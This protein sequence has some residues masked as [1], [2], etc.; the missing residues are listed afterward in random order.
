MSG[1]GKK[2]EYEVGKCADCGRSMKISPRAKK[3][4]KYCAVCRL[5]RGAAWCDGRTTTCSC[6]REYVA[7]NGAKSMQS[8]GFCF[9]EHAPL[10][11]REAV[12][13]TCGYHKQG[14]CHSDTETVIYHEKLKLCYPCLHDP[15]KY[16]DTKRAILRRGKELR[17]GSK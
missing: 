11:G 15:E 10:G 13:G 16:D 2:R 14:T 12:P 8:C 1:D 17:A 7:W 5:A 4:Q 6:G 9:I 3:N